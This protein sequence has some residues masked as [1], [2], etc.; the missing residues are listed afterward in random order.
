MVQ[1]KIFKFNQKDLRDKFSKENQLA[2]LV[3][4]LAV[5]TAD[6]EGQ[7]SNPEGA[8]VDNGEG[9]A[10]RAVDGGGKCLGDGDDVTQLLSNTKDGA[11]IT[12]FHEKLKTLN[13]TY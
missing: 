4:W 3:K 2:D 6:P 12:I 7:G 13:F 8:E 1:T 10:E 11:Q 5:Q 9:G